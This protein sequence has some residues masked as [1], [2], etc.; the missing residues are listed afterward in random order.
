MATKQCGQ[1]GWLVKAGDAK[2]S[3][4]GHCVGSEVMS[5]SQAFLL[6]TSRRGRQLTCWHARAHTHS[7]NMTENTDY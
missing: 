2:H 1:E 3:L 6:E 4:A 5:S 7:L